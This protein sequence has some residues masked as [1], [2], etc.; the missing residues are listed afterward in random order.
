MPLLLLLLQEDADYP[1]IGNISSLHREPL[2]HLGNLLHER[3]DG[4]KLPKSNKKLL[5]R[6]LLVPKNKRRTGIPWHFSP[7]LAPIWKQNLGAKILRKKRKLRQVLPHPKLLRLPWRRL[8]HHWRAVELL[9][10][11]KK[12]H[13]VVVPLLLQTPL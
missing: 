2:L 1:F 4:L 7:R 10:L 9:L 6:K 12:P 11:P 8:P 3:K 5:A 13:T